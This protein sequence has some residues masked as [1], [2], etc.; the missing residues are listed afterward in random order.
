MKPMA[1][2]WYIPGTMQARAKTPSKDTTASP[3]S[4]TNKQYSSNKM[5]IPSS[6][7]ILHSLV[8]THVGEI[9][10]FILLFA[11]TA[12]N[13][14]MSFGAQKG[15]SCGKMQKKNLRALPLRPALRLMHPAMEE[16]TQVGSAVISL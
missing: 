15:P 3:V 6:A 12:K 10:V 7:V 5:L 1:E 16:Q 14:K 4:P 11:E 13:A 2:A 9:C 8:Y